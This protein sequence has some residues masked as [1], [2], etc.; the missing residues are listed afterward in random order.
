[1]LFDSVND[2]LK[3]KLSALTHW[4]EK[5]IE[6]TRAWDNEL[7]SVYNV[8][9]ISSVERELS[10]LTPRQTTTA[11]IK[12]L[13]KAEPYYIGDA[14]ETL[15]ETA[16][17]SLPIDATLPK[18]E[19]PEDGF[20]L[21]ADPIRFHWNENDKDSND[22][23]VDFIGFHFAYKPHLDSI[24]LWWYEWRFERI[25]PFAAMSWDFTTSLVEFHDGTVKHFAFDRLRRF[26]LSFLV[27]LRQRILISEKHQPR[28][29][30]G[31]GVKY[32][33]TTLINVIILRKSIR[34]PRDGD[35]QS[36]DIDWQCRW[37]VRG[38]WRRQFYPSTHTNSPMWI[39]PYIKGPED[40]PLKQ[41][42]EIIFAVVR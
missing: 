40:K 11:V 34:E 10:P 39:V 14:V 17:R 3:L 7:E 4:G 19:L 5:G 15:I 13:Q 28:K 35:A 20:V 8:P 22:D 16:G 27:F 41:P 42:N 29:V 24:M 9:P 32:P 12:D 2:A 1:M 33:I 21:L 37:F 36:T 30:K 38:H 26:C 6:W 31:L 23:P 25:F 18:A